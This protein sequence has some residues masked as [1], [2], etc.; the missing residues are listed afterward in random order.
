[1]KL[2]KVSLRSGHVT[3]Q[4]PDRLTDVV[5]AN[6]FS[7]ALKETNQ[8]CNIHFKIESNASHYWLYRNHHPTHRNNQL[9][10]II[11]ALEWQVFEA[12]IRQNRDC[13]QFHAAVMA[14]NDKAFMF[15]GPAGTGKTSLCL[16]LMR[17]GWS[18]F[19]DEIALLEPDT[20][21]LFPFPR[22]II[23]KPHLNSLIEPDSRRLIIKFAGADNRV[24]PGFFV[25]PSYFTPQSIAAQ[26]LTLCGIILLDG[27]PGAVLRIMPLSSAAAFQGV[28][29]NL[30]NHHCFRDHALHYLLTLL[31][32]CKP[33]KL[34]L[35]NP[36]FADPVVQ[37]ELVR[38]LYGANLC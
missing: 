31:N 14:R 23:I 5:V 6:I 28:I 17:Q 27:S 37:N 2:F 36:L 10:K 24:Y 29:A 26:P 16:F 20:R 18:F 3:I 25:P 9:A 38:I 21:L 15:I 8:R 35:P 11:Y 19:S 34:S 22:N 33:V 1:M 13:L 30:F 12:L 4:I 7:D 32:Q